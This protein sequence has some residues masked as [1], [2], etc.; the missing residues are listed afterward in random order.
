[1]LQVA[2]LSPKLLGDSRECVA[3]FVQN[4]LMPDGGF[5]N[6][7]GV[8]DLYYTVFGVHA[9]LALHEVIPVDAIR[10][11]LDL[12]EDGASLDLVHLASLARCWACITKNPNQ[13]P[14]QQTSFTHLI[15]QFRS[16]D[17]AFNT[18]PASTQGT[19][20]GTFLVFGACQ[21]VGMELP[22]IDWINQWMNTLQCKDGGFSNHP[23]AIMGTTT[24]TAAAVM[25]MHSAG[26]PIP[27]K[28]RDWLLKRFNPKGGGFF[29]SPRA[30]M[31]D[32][33]S[34]A[35]ALHALE[36]MH[37]PLE[38]IQE[39][40][41][42]FLDSLWSSQGGFYGTWVDD[43]LDCEYTYYGLLSLGHLSF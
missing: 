1:M 29:A 9:L 16:D 15:E 4:S 34:T 11:F 42:D 27:E 18:V 36:R 30:P 40:C 24:S 37:A 13:S 7:D 10:N 2:R 43:K 17:G 35:T 26:I 25:I 31:P 14:L 12:Y 28:V 22:D 21:D 8:S 33:L 6:R 32:L 5:R 41:L 39:A 23:K 3:A 38:P 19:L 20:Y